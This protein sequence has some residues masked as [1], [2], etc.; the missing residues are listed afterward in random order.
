MRR[1]SATFLLTAMVTTSPAICL[2][3]T[4]ETFVSQ[5]SSRLHDYGQC[6]DDQHRATPIHSQTA[7][8]AANARCER[9]LRNIR[10]LS[11]HI[12]DLL[13]EHMKHRVQQVASKR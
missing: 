13:D 11:P 4:S 6:I 9:E 8:D 10:D 5:L 1:T 3:E 2:A 7:L 12:A